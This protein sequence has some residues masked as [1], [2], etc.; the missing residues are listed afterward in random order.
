[1]N[2]LEKAWGLLPFGCRHN[3]LSVPFSMA[4]A[5]RQQHMY[6]DVTDELPP[7]CSHYVVCLKCGRRFG[8]DWG[9]MKVIKTRAVKAK[10]KTAG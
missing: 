9:S 10:L 3:N 1:L 2:L 4:S 5:A 6:V 8:Y 7:G